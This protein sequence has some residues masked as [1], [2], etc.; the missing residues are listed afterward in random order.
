[1]SLS[2]ISIAETG[3][4]SFSPPSVE[5]PGIQGPEIGPDRPATLEHLQALTTAAAMRE[6][7]AAV[8]EQVVI[9]SGHLLP[10]MEQPAR[11]E[12]PKREPR[13]GNSDIEE[14][15]K[16]D[17]GGEDPDKPQDQL[18]GLTPRLGSIGLAPPRRLA[19]IK[20]EIEVFAKDFPLP[21]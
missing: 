2:S 3:S 15:I 12:L 9:K 21:R 18:S 16:R 17:K 4:N 1:M 8:D 13:E 5:Q 11:K 14:A 20:A 10:T 19:K 7:G 6:L